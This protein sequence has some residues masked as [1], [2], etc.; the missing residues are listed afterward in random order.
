MVAAYTN[1]VTQRL[2]SLVLADFSNLQ[3]LRPVGGNAWAETG[4]IGSTDFG[5]S[6]RE[7]SGVH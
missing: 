2:G 5:S 3:G 6:R 1:G 4:Q 7:R